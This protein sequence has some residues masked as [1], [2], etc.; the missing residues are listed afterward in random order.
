MKNTIKIN[1]KS[2]I[3]STIKAIHTQSVSKILHLL[4]IRDE[5]GY[6]AA[7]EVME[8]L[9]LNAQDTNEN[10][11]HNLMILLSTSLEAYEQSHFPVP[12][13]SGIDVLRYLMEENKMKQADLLSIFGSR[14]IVSEIL[15][16]K[17]ELTKRHIKE[18]AQFFKVAPAV[19]L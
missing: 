14:G 2:A 7:L 5:E 13:V 4:A 8:Y 17:R 9:M 16:E 11:Y 1:G 10:T 3:K 19:F 6:Q 18:L 12:E 15:S